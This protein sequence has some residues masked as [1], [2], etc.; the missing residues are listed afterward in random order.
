MFIS[1]IDGSML[2]MLSTIETL[3]NLKH[4]LSKSFQ[5]DAQR[6]IN[7]LK[8]TTYRGKNSNK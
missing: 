6:Y 8:Q 7:Y 1:D 2:Q 3:I 5:I 4:I